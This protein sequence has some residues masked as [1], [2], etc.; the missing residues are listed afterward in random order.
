M[1]YSNTIEPPTCSAPLSVIISILKASYL[2][3]F[4]NSDLLPI[5]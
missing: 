2:L 4:R 5:Q 3:G 1:T